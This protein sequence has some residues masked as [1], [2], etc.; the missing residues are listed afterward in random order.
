MAIVGNQH[1]DESSGFEQRRVT[2]NACLQRYRVTSRIIQGSGVEKERKDSGRLMDV[3]QNEHVRLAV[4]SSKK[5]EPTL[6]H[7]GSPA[8]SPVDSTSF[9]HYRCRPLFRQFDNT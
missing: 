4:A 3:E 2:H 7:F 1:L 9:L 8:F 5:F 6:N